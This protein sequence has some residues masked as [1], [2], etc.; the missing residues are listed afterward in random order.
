MQIFYTDMYLCS[1][2]YTISFIQL[3]LFSVFFLP[4]LTEACMTRKV[5]AINKTK[6]RSLFLRVTFAL[7]ESN[8]IQLSVLLPQSY[9]C[10]D[11][12]PSY[13]V[14]A[15]TAATCTETRVTRVQHSTVGLNKAQARTEAKPGWG[16]ARR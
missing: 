5:N 12:G 4:K 15:T 10:A 7:N 8:F 2:Y 14:Q 6:K 16:E 3:C 13:R 9:T 11:G 1:I